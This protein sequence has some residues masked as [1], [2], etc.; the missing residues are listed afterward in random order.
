M[1]FVC[2]QV[3]GNGPR[4]NSIRGCLQSFYVPGSGYVPLMFPVPGLVPG[5]DV[6]NGVDTRYGLGVHAYCL[7]AGFLNP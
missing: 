6:G 1:Q 4:E 7:P 5:G 2:G 3:F